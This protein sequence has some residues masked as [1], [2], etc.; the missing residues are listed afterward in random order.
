MK[1]G[2]FV[3]NIKMMVITHPFR[4]TKVECC[5][6]QPLHMR[7]LQLVDAKDGLLQLFFEKDALPKSHMLHL[8]QVFLLFPSFL[9]FN[10]ELRVLKVCGNAMG[11][12]W[13]NE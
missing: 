8:G 13:K 1:L 6:L 12:L 4:A 3:I 9:N 5:K 7:K 2:C 11:S 10:E